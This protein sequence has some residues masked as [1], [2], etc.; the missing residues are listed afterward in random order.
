MPFNITDEAELSKLSEYMID[1]PD[2]EEK[3]TEESEQSIIVLR[4][5]FL[6]L[7]GNYDG[8]NQLDYQN[9]NEF[10]MFVSSSTSLFPKILTF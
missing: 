5:I 4:S 1:D 6:K 7:L 10:I 3:I 9:C 2:S 8:K